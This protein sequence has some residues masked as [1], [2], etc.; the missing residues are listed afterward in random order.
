MIS[1]KNRNMLA[2]AQAAALNSDH[3]YRLGAVIVSGSR[4][5]GVGWNKT[6][7][8]PANVSFK[9]IK[10][11][12]VHAEVDALR[13]LAPLRRA[14]CFVARLDAYGSPTLARPCDDCWQALTDAGVTKVYWTVD[15]ETVGVSRVE[16]F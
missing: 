1:G 2:I 14:S 16:H 9:H 8:R 3:R 5:M 15:E 6:R 4:V 10:E 13:G 7:N 12:T 11:C